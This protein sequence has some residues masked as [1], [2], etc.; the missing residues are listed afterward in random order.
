MN[1]R[2]KGVSSKGAMDGFS[3]QIHLDRAKNVIYKKQLTTVVTKIERDNL[4]YVAK[5]R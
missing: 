3:D 5:V 4:G 1:D 2:I